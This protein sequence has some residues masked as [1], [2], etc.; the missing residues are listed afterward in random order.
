MGSKQIHTGSPDPNIT[1]DIYPIFHE[2][3]LAEYT[4]ANFFSFD[5][6]F[7]TT[8]YP[9]PAPEDVVEIIDWRNPEII[10]AEDGTID[11]RPYIWGFA[12][13]TSRIRLAAGS[14]ISYNCMALNHKGVLVLDDNVHEDYANMLV[15]RAIGYS[16]AHLDYFFRGKIDIQNPVI[17]Y[18]ADSSITG[19][20]FTMKN[21]TLPLNNSQTIEPFS[22]GT[23]ELVIGYTAPDGTTRRHNAGTIYDVYDATDPINFEFRTITVDLTDTPLPAGSY[24]LS[25]TV[26]FAGKL[27]NEDHG[28][29]AFTGWD[30]GCRTRTGSERFLLL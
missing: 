11:Y 17:D 28:I 7:T 10:V 23:I 21:G 24:H 16:T 19:L 4:N 8:K 20:S 2:I 9:H 25:F 13:G 3:G 5:T 18:G 26:I 29:A 22:S 6:I 15:P 30:K 14:L 12:G 27:G 1:R